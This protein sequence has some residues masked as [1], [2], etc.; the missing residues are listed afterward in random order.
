MIIMIIIV[1]TYSKTLTKIIKRIQG[2]YYPT[3]QNTQNEQE[4]AASRS[5]PGVS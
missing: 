3:K 4:Q 2:G 1:L 5:R